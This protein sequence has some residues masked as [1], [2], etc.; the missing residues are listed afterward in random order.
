MQQNQQVLTRDIQKKMLG[1]L[2][3]FKQFCEEHDLK[4]VLCGG[5]CLG[6][7]RHKGF[8]PWDDDVDVFMLREDYEKLQAL[9]ERDADTER[10]A[11]VRSNETIN[12]HHSA[13]EIK[14]NNTTFINGHSVDVDMNHGVMIDVI[15][16]DGVPTSGWNRFWQMVNSMVY[17]CFNFQRLPE[18]KGKV[19]YYATKLALG[20]IRSPKLRYQIWKGAER[21]LSRYGTENCAQVASFGEGATI[22]RM[23]FPTEWFRDVGYMD[24]EGHQMPVPGDVDQYLKITFGDY[25]QLP[26]VEEQVARHTAVFIDMDNSYKKYKGIH[27]CV[28]K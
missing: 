23:R 12:I 17:C 25:M 21:R 3:Y 14:D 11:C 27:Y 1:I 22:M 9:W 10:Y 6:A 24:F 18:H 15:P 8:I 20:V 28:K 5:T 26:P 13:M 4:F 2:V 16:V 7:V 19:T